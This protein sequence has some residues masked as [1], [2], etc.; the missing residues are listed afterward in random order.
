MRTALYSEPIV[1]TPSKD[2]IANDLI[3]LHQALF[4]KEAPNVTTL[5]TKIPVYQP[6]WTKY[7]RT[8]AVPI[9]DLPKGQTQFLCFFTLLVSAVY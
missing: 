1:Q 6:L 5:R 4:L 2:S 7:L 9:L 3:A 8:M